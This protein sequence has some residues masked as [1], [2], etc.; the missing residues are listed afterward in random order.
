LQGGHYVAYS[1]PWYFLHFRKAP[2]QQQ[3]V[4]DTFL[5]IGQV[6]DKTDKFNNE[7]AGTV[8]SERTASMK[9]YLTGPMQSS[10]L[11]LLR[12]Q[13]VSYKYRLV[14]NMGHTIL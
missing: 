13:Q 11:I 14:I 3:K 10:P 6:Y 2:A 4:F 5:Q 9:G 7:L 8:C 1:K 12:R